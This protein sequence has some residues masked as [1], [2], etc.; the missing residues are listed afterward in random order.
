VEAWLV[1]TSK[2]VNLTQLE[3]KHAFE[4][5]QFGLDIAFKAP[6]YAQIMQQRLLVFRPSIVRR[7]NGFT[8]QTDPRTTPV[9]LDAECY[10]KQVRVKLPSSFKVDEMPDAASFSTPFGKYS[11][12]YKLEGGDL[13]FTEELDIS[14]ATIP[15]ER[16]AEV[17]TF[18]EHVAGAEQ[19]PLVLVKN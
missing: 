9:A 15:A 18:F 7:W 6:S 10:H 11:S 8:V 4:K 2:E 14:A 1:E 5:E 17:K 12:S 13:L 3:A 16:Y 19:Q